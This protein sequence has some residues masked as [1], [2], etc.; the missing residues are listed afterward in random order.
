MRF[1]WGL[2][3]GPLGEGLVLDEGTLAAEQAVADV[4]ELAGGVAK[5]AQH[6]EQR[7]PAGVGP[8]GAAPPPAAVHAPPQHRVAQEEQQGQA[9]GRPG[10][11]QRHRGEEKS[12]EP[13]APR[14]AHPEPY[15]SGAV[16]PRHLAK[17]WPARTA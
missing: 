14:L 17:A 15:R 13:V 7:V 1:S 6:A 10:A 8:R 3:R 5:L 9:R 12:P 2:A 16:N 11:N 4:A